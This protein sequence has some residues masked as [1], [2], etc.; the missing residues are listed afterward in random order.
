MHVWPV[1]R[2]PGQAFF[3]ETI[4]LRNILCISAG[5]SI[6]AVLRWVLALAFN[7]AIPLIPL[8][9]LV[10]NLAGGYI[11]GVMLAVVAFYPQVPLEAKL[12]AITGFLGALT[13]FSAFSGEVVVLI[14]Q[15]HIFAATMTIILHVAGSLAMTG[16]GIV[17]GM[18]FLLRGQ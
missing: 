8:G 2:L 12:F 17:T 15:R 11:M 14:Q 10:A 18:F 16:L 13:T 1:P 7:S 9:T 3:K 5:A 6:G 4:M